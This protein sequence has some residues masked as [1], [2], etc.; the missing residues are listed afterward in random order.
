MTLITLR[1]CVGCDEAQSKPCAEAELDRFF[2]TCHISHVL[3]DQGKPAVNKIVLIISRQITP[4]VAGENISNFNLMYPNVVMRHSGSGWAL[5]YRRPVNHKP[6]LAAAGIDGEAGVTH[7]AVVH[8]TREKFSSSV[9]NPIISL[10]NT[11]PNV[12]GVLFSFII[13]LSSRYP[14]PNQQLLRSFAT[15]YPNLPHR[16]HAP[17]V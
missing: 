17:A 4:G 8:I 14:I 9:P 15:K 3:T 12:G 6:P 7:S 10:S 16:N 2:F 1:V 11:R 13:R 5:C